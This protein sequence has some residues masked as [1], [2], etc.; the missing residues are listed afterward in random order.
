M[1]TG[2]MQMTLAD[3]AAAALDATHDK[4]MIGL[5]T[6]KLRWIV[7]TWLDGKLGA[8]VAKA[9]TSFIRKAVT[10]LEGVARHRMAGGSGSRWR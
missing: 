9:P 8:K 4:L 10:T 3:R 6:E 5:H 2:A 7:A 1:T